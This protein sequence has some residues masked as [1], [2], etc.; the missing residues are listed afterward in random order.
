MGLLG[1]IVAFLAVVILMLIPLVGV[2]LGHMETLFGIAIPYTAALIFLGGV[3]YRVIIWA[4]SPVPFKIPTTCGQEKSLPW[5]KTNWIDNPTNIFAVI[6]RMALEVLLFR[7]LFRNTALD[8]RQGRVYYSSAKWL[9]GAAL[10]FHWSFLVVLIRHLRFFTE[11][12][13]MAISL[14]ENL[15]GWVEIGLWPFT[16][17][18]GLFLSGVGLLMAATYLFL[19]RVFIPQLRYI[20]LSNDWFPLLLIIHIAATGILMRYILKVDI[21]TIKELTMGLV[22][23]SAKPPQGLDVLFYMHLFLVSA[24]FAYFPFSK[25][26]HAGGVFLSPTRNTINNTRRVRHVNPWNPKVA[27]H[28][29]DAYEDEFREFMI[30]ADI[31]V[32]KEAA[33][34][35]AESDKE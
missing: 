1:F 10:V 32:E 4:K 25:L 5:I 30:E 15:D 35:A 9:W 16:W 17:M 23:F 29:Y 22:T 2:G 27:V 12:V 18:P 31:P 24:L 11:P 7:S 13:P 19:R 28:S 34:T 3:L 14:L 21:V 26:M 20:S 8:F 6:I 33:D